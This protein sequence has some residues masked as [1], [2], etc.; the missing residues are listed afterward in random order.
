MTQVREVR[1]ICEHTLVERRPIDAVHGIH[2][3]NGIDAIGSI[4]D[5]VA[6]GHDN[7]VIRLVP[8]LVAGVDVYGILTARHVD[9]VAAEYDDVLVACWDVQAPAITVVGRADFATRPSGA[10]IQSGYV[11]AVDLPTTTGTLDRRVGV[12]EDTLKCIGDVQA[13]AGSAVKGAGEIFTLVIDAARL[14]SPILIDAV[15][16]FVGRIRAVLEREVGAVVAQVDIDLYAG[17]GRFAQTPLAAGAPVAVLLVDGSRGGAH[18]GCLIDAALK[19]S[20]RGHI[21]GNG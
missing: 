7:I 10:G 9:L 5:V 13:L 19:G 16:R 17:T 6:G 20:R 3:V 14:V 8:H 4:V 1:Q 15:A 11:H 21:N 12:L 18:D 2:L